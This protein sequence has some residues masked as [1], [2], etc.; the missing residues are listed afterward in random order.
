MSLPAIEL[1]VAHITIPSFTNTEFMRIVGHF[2]GE[3]FVKVQRGRKEPVGIRVCEPRGSKF[4]KTYEDLYRKVF[5][6][7][8]FE[9]NDGQKFA[10]ASTPLAK[11]FKALGLAHRAREK[12]IPD[13]VFSLPSDQRQ[14]FIQGY[15]EADGPIRHRA[16]TK[17][18]PDWKGRY[19]F[20]TIEHDTVAVETT[21]EMLVRQLHELCLMSGYRSD[22]IRAEFTE[23]KQLP[24]GRVA[25]H[26]TSHGFEFSL[27]VDKNPFK[28]ARVTS[29]ERAGEVETYDLQVE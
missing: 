26:S 14:G 11:L 29:I 16:A 7:H 27:K 15:A 12:R 13:W 25:R 23:E 5:N 2:V 24:E 9:D 3:G 28:L 18:L 17:A 19:R 6:C 20:V 21:N 8:I 10:V 4:R 22:N 1:E